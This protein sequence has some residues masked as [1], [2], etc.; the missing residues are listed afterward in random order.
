M[1]IEDS[2][3][4]IDSEETL[5]IHEIIHTLQGEST[6]AG[7]RVALV[8]LQ[9]CNIRCKWCDTDYSI[10]RG[11]GNKMAVD[12]IIAKVLSYQC[13]YVLITGGEPLFQEN[14][15]P[16]MT[17]LCDLGLSVSLETSGSILIDR[18]DPRVIRIVDFK[19]PASGMEKY[20]IYEN[21]ALL[22]KND[23]VKFVIADLNDYE[24]SKE[25]L[26]RYNLHEKCRAVLFSPVSGAIDY[27][28]LANKIITEKLPVRFQAQL[29]KIIWGLN[30][31]GN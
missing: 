17:K 20:N 21:A 30:S 13:S 4:I 18:V 11:Q 27:M 7:C 28:V 15:Y 31:R 23:E 1:K 8:R 9:G 19:C 24:W 29:H 12:D 3:K 2:R 16:L 22:T 25:I 5:E 26:F 6:R 10:K 14:V